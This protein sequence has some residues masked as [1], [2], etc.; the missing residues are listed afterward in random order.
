M[1]HDVIGGE[2]RREFIASMKA[3]SPIKREG[4]RNRV[5][6]TRGVNQR[7]WGEHNGEPAGFVL[8]QPLDGL[9]YVATVVVIPAAAGLGIGLLLMIGVEHRA[10]Q[11]KAAGP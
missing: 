11:L 1:P 10:Q 9:L 5:C 8:L 7:A 4:E 3:L 2:V 6:G